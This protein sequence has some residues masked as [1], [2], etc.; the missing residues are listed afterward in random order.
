[1]VYTIR[2]EWLSTGSRNHLFVRSVVIRTDSYVLY[3]RVASVTLSGLEL[4]V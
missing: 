3:S 4:F 2:T 1:M